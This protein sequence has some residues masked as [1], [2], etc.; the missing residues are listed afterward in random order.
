[1][2]V[3]PRRGSTVAGGHMPLRC[4]SCEGLWVDLHDVPRLLEHRA[5]ALPMP[6]PAEDAKDLDSRTGLCPLGHGRLGRVRVEVDDGFYLDRCST[7][8]G[9]W[10]DRGEWQ[11]LARRELLHRLPE[12]WT[13]AWQ[14]HQRNVQQREAYL[15]WAQAEFGDDLLAQLDELAERLRTHPQRSA[16]ITYLL[17]ES[18]LQPSGKGPES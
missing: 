1:V 4:S 6:E 10:F 3:K 9:I 14:R 16:A 18:R 5:F 2:R 15:A 11:R 12:F 8:A 13:A 17:Q 7:C